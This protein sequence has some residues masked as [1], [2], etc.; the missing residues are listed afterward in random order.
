M[1]F[2]GSFCRIAGCRSIWPPRHCVP[3][4][5][6]E[7]LGVN[8]AKHRAVLELATRYIRCNTHAPHGQKEARHLA[9]EERL[10]DSVGSAGAPHVAQL[11][12]EKALC[13]SP[14][15]RPTPAC[16]AAPGSGPL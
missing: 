2:S 16:T 8:W 15:C 5:M 1:S 12:L 10:S 14:S 11:N 13:A 3:A 4:A 9:K 7:A 6:G